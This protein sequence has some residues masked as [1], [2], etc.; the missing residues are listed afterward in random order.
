MYNFRL[1]SYGNGTAQLTYFHKPIRMKEDNYKIKPATAFDRMSEKEYDHYL[2]IENALGDNSYY[3]ENE[4]ILNYVDGEI[5]KDVAP[6]ELMVES[7]FGDYIPA[8]ILP[9]VP[10]IK[11]QPEFTPEELA[12]K[13][14]RS[15]IS[16]VNRSKKK[17]YDYGRS[18]VWEWFFTLTFEPVEQFTAENF[19]ECKKKVGKWFKNIRQNYCKNIKYLAIPEQHESGAWHF[20]CLVSNC[21]ELDF[22]IAKNTRRY[23]KDKKGNYILDKNGARIPNQYFGHDL[24][25]SYPDGN[26]IYNIKQY[27]NGWSTATRIIDTKRAVSYVIKYVTKELSECAFG[28]RRYLPSKNLDLPV[29]TYALL[30]NKELMQIITD[31]EYKFGLKLSIDCIKTYTIDVENYSNMVTLFEFDAPAVDAVDDSELKAVRLNEI[32]EAW[33]E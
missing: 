27:K 2:R 4:I 25:T 10:K 23:L 15:I 19:D 16:S 18:N 12:E 9:P 22:E 7:P 5:I 6:A 30:D 1:K 8:S 24:R 33:Y 17:I 14:E 31:I 32:M 26:Y 3:W 28:K 20:H 13:R 21:E 11:K 29:E